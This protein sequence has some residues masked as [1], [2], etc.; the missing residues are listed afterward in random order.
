[1]KID[2]LIN[3]C[4]KNKQFIFDLFKW[5]NLVITLHWVSLADSARSAGLWP[6]TVKHR[7]PA[8]LRQPIDQR[9]CDWMA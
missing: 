7:K 6:D 8:A 3:N 9:Q 5:F 4:A 1:M 2:G